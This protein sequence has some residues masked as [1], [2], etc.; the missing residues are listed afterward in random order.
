MRLLGFG[1]KE[2]YRIGL[3]LSG[4]GAR[5]F[6]HAGAINL[7]PYLAA[8]SFDDVDVKERVYVE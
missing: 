2:P 1:R 8:F 6:A 4:G 5:G 3:A 7:V